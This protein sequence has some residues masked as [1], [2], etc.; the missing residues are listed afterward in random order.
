M[1]IQ[2]ERELR[3]RLGALLDG[4]APGPA[5]VSQAVRR[6]RGIRVRRWIGAAAGLAVIVAGAA[7][8]PALLQAHTT[9]PAAPLHYKVTVTKLGGSAAGGVIGAGTIGTEHWRVVLDPW[10]V[11]C[12]PGEAGQR[13]VRR[14]RGS[15]PSSCLTSYSDPARVTTFVAR[16]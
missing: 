15:S 6:G 14:G 13:R 3:G 2:D 4:V 7:V 12:G 8:V 16:C 1:S 11:S 5:P 9:T 10:P